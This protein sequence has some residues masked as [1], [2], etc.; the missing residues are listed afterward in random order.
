MRNRSMWFV[1]L[2]LPAAMAGLPAPGAAQM[3]APAAAPMAAP[4][5]AMPANYGAL[6]ALF[7]EWRAF[8][9]S[10]TANAAVDY[11]PA[12]TARKAA[13]LA[14]FQS[15]LNAINTTGW[16]ESALID[17]KLVQAELNGLDFELRVLKPWVR[18]PTFYANV[19]PDMSDVP[20]HEGPYAHPNIDLYK[21]NFPLSP[22][23]DRRLTAMI[24]NVPAILSA[25]KANL[26]PGNVKDFWTYG[27]RAFIEQAETLEA[28]RN[29]TL[30][31]RTLKGRFKA[32]TSGASP[33]LKRAIVAAEAATIDFAAHIRAEAPRKSGSAGLG[34]EN[35]NW[36]TKNV[37]M[38]P[39]DWDQ[40][41]VLLRREL[42]RSI[43]SMRLEEVRNRKLP[44]IKEIDNTEA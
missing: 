34:K 4:T 13:T 43:T 22:A 21:F 41:V 37:A 11:T 28:L 2:A 31:M 12:A 39:Y 14:S 32:D 30:V 1:A 24:A 17:R 42:D 15:R 27:E 20:A 26:A 8:V 44:P 33:A 16:S 25:A 7:A 38:M 36:Y 6:T 35:Y 19:I 18:D 5:T 40:Q 3:V 23:D 29:N 10:P 9:M